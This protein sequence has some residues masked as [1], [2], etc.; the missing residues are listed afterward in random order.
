M[1]YFILSLCLFSQFTFAGVQNF[2]NFST[3]AND[4]ILSSGKSWEDGSKYVGLHGTTIFGNACA[5]FITD[6]GAPGDYY[7]AVGVSEKDA[8][9]TEDQTNQYLGGLIAKDLEKADFYMRDGVIQYKYQA[10]EFGSEINLLIKFTDKKVISATG[11]TPETAP[12]SC[13]F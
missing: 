7:I 6:K 11:W 13:V 2:D 10:T 8:F 1:R 5:L 12:L 4:L 9:D 3:W